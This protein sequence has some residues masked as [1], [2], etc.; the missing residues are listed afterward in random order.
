MSKALEITSR[1]KFC[2]NSNKEVYIRR[3]GDWKEYYAIFCSNCHHSNAKLSE[4][5]PT[6]KGAIKIW[7]SY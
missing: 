5:S 7:N 2:K 4:A 3:V 1:C 6:I